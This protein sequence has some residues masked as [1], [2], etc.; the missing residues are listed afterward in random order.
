MVMDVN[1]I[2]LIIWDLDETFWEGTLS[3]GEV[4]MKD[5]CLQIVK[6]STAKGIVNAICSKN[7]EKDVASVLN[8]AQIADFFVFN[9]IDWTP[10]GKRIKSMLSNMG[11]RSA[12]TLFL[13]DNQNNIGEALFYNKDL[14]TLEPTNDNLL[15]LFN[16]IKKMEGSSKGAGRLESYKQLEKKYKAKSEFSSNEEFLFSC[17]MRV[18]I[19]YDCL[20]QLDRISE[21][22]LRT[23]QLNYTKNRSSIDELRAVMQDKDYK[24]GYVKAQDNFGDYGIIGFFALF[25]PDNNLKHFLFSCRTIGQGVEQ[26]VYSKLDFPHLTVVGDV[27]S[28]VDKKSCPKWI[29]QEVNADAE[30]SFNK[31]DD[32]RILFKGPCD[33]MALT[34]Y[35]KVKRGII[36]TEFT[37]VGEKN[38]V[39]ES[40]N[41]SVSMRALY[42]YSNQEKEKLV[43]DCI[44]MDKDYYKSNLFTKEYDFIFLSSLQ[45]PG[46]GIY[47][48][49][50]T[51]LYVPF[52][53]AVYPLTDKR[54]WSDYIHGRVYHG[55]NRFSEEFLSWF[56]DNYVFIG[57]NTPSQYIENIDY[58]IS[59][60]DAHTRFII[61]LGS[62]IP[63]LKED[64]EAY[65]NR[66]VQNKS[67]N[68]AIREYANKSNGKVLLIDVNK[69]IKG[70]ADFYDS[71]SHFSLNVYYQIAQDMIRLIND[72]TGGEFVEKRGRFVVIKEYINIK[73]RDTVRWLFPNREGKL[74]RLLQKIYRIAKL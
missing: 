26:Y 28:M 10:K 17:N 45:E 72:S 27:I 34:K 30:K 18:D 33:L 13:D 12:N 64:S 60:T 4:R 5:I 39:I 7:E 9:S 3:E 68:D 21:L 73:L 2:K 42:D 52:A 67:F 1:K 50:G 41:H 36:D 63:F 22:V 19:Q 47:Q 8:D 59:K 71:I 55:M 46:M 29:N 32:V 20:N 61:F 69:Y 16:E 62:E 53:N 56:S 54:F 43:N 23:N 65:E 25:I 57:S 38:N 11:L 66:H 6:I 37:Y 70:Q 48:K 15:H 74:Y 49:K 24:C 51:Q 31:L 40:H 14:M 58:I 35:L 44:F